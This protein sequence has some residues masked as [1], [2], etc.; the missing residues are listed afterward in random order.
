M[1]QPNG[2]LKFYNDDQIVRAASSIGKGF[3]PAFPDSPSLQ[4][5]IDMEVAPPGWEGPIKKMKKDPNIDNP[6]ALAYWMKNRGFMPKSAK[7]KSSEAANFDRQSPPK[8]YP[9]DTGK[10]ADP[11]NFKYPVDSPKRTRSAISYF[12][13]PDNRKGYSS[14]EQKTI[15]GRIRKAS[16]KF[17]IEMQDNKEAVSFSGM[18]PLL[19]PGKKKEGVKLNSWTPLLE[20]KVTDVDKR[21]VQVIIM[22]EGLGNKRD[23]HYYSKDC[24]RNAAPLFEG[25]RAFVDHPT[26]TEEITRPERTLRDLIGYYSDVAPSEDGTQLLGTLCLEDTDA[27][28]QWFD[29]IKSAID[30]SQRYPDKVYFAISINADGKTHQE[31][32]N[33]ETVNIVDA[34]TGVD[35]ADLVTRPALQTKFVKIMQSMRE[36]VES[37]DERRVYMLEAKVRQAYSAEAKRLLKMSAEAE[38]G[39]MQQLDDLKKGLDQMHDA[40]SAGKYAMGAEAQAALKRA[41]KSCEDADDDDGLNTVF[42]HI[43]N[44]VDKVGDDSG[45]DKD[46]DQKMGKRK[47]SEDEDEAKKKSSEA[48]DEDEKNSE[49]E[50]EDEARFK[51]A[52]RTAEAEDEDEDEAKKKSSEARRKASEDEDED[53]NEAEP[54]QE[55]MAQ[56]EARLKKAEAKLKKAFKM[57]KRKANETE[58]GGDPSPAAGD[59]GQLV[60]HA[61]SDLYPQKQE[62]YAD[63]SE[64]ESEARKKTNESLRR[65]NVNSLRETAAGKLAAQSRVDRFYEQQRQKVADRLRDKNFVENETNR[66]AK[67][68]MKTANMLLQESNLPEKTHRVVMNDLLDCS[69]EKEMRHVI[70]GYE[71]FSV[72]SD[73]DRMVEEYTR[74]EGAGARREMRE[75]NNEDAKL[76]RLL[77]GVVKDFA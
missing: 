22:S 54:D 10:Y 24:I 18:G 51:K 29:K 21:K 72:A 36:A 2:H 11:K 46:G 39:D 52:K 71:A 40:I 25:A 68:L 55:P 57:A 67:I 14:D 6:F 53:A 73:S 35:S 7:K 77:Q 74:V 43:K 75:S 44:F 37:G 56:K 41:M 12:S 58:D 34:I 4:K 31:D 38:G 50:D 47:T 23:M 76:A 32:Q 9:K 16:K 17:G 45:G 61:H 13:N 28:Q 33:G 48:E 26:E 30:Y 5:Q 3:K 65:A 8:Y 1:K 62:A 64:D 69:N 66:Q 20:A 63:D 27:G 42:K 59:W 70:E 60:K 19:R 15:W 49:A